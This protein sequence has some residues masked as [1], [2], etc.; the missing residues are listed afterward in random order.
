M[1]FLMAALKFRKKHTI[2]CKNVPDLCFA[3]TAIWMC[4]IFFGGGGGRDCI[5]SIQL[6]YKQ[7]VNTAKQNS[8]INSS[9]YIFCTE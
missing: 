5:S 2:T 6:K 1:G 8:E 4:T 3:M 9:E 7:E